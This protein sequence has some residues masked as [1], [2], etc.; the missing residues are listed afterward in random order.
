M[1]KSKIPAAIEAVLFAM[2]GSVEVSEIA[3]ALEI[4]EQEAWEAVEAIREKLGHE[5][6]GLQINRYDDAVQL[7]TRAEYYE[8]LIKI[9]SVP[10][11]QTLTNAMLETLSIIAYRQPVTRAEIEHIRGVNSDHSVNKLLSYDLVEEVGRKEA[12]GRPILFGTTEQFLRTF[13]I[14]SLAELPQTDAVKMA[15]FQQEAEEEAGADLEI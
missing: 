8:Y 4:T 11:K 6:S 10:K 9:A 7:S 13:G 3:Q 1:E 15:E 2:G 5:G 12:P 14:S